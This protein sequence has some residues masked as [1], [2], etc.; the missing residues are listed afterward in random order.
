MNENEFML[1]PAGPEAEEPPLRLF[2]DILHNR[3]T[4]KNRRY[5]K[6]P[7]TLQTPKY[8]DRDRYRHCDGY[9]RRVLVSD[10]N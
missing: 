6:Q 2:E 7:R 1:P 3:M 9:Y 10:D 4:Q 5:T 8:M